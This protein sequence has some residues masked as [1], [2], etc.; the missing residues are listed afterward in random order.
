M[1]EEE[2]VSDIWV[3]CDREPNAEVERRC[4]TT[5]EKKERDGKHKVLG[6][7]RGKRCIGRGVGKSAKLFFVRKNYCII[8]FTCIPRYCNRPRRSRQR[9]SRQSRRRRSHSIKYERTIRESCTLSTYKI[10]RT[11]PCT[12][13]G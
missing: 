5:R 11:T 12:V 10:H 8:I 6:V 4:D 13:A 1:R 7:F 9:Y 3:V 2:L